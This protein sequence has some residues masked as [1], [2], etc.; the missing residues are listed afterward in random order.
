MWGKTR[1]KGK[2]HKKKKKTKHKIRKQKQIKK[3]H[4]TFPTCFRVLVNYMY[5][6]G[7]KRNVKMF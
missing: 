2:K 7:P 6:I 4:V 1:K 5:N 3:K